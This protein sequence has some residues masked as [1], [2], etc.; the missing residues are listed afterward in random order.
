MTFNITKRTHLGVVH[1]RT[2]PPM[3]CSHERKPESDQDYVSFW[4][5][6]ENC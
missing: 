3:K 1:L 6:L 2:P 4:E 5:T